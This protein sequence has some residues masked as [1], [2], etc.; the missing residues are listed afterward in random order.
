[1]CN[2]KE[3]TYFCLEHGL[4]YLQER[5]ASQRKNCTLYYTHSK[6]EISGLIRY[7]AI[8]SYINLDQDISTLSK[9]LVELRP[10]FE[11]QKTWLE[12]YGSSFLIMK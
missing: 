12:K 3:D 7:Y 5:K 2:V 1:M 8:D 9:N 11:F 10:V 6:E 4:E